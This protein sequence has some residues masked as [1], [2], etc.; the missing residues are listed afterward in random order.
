MERKG[1]EKLKG[2]LCLGS[3]GLELKK[4][5]FKGHRKNSS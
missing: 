1:L 5:L 3:V 2:F 4:G